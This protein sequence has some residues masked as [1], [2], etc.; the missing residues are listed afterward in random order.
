MPVWRS[1]ESNA[2][3]RRTGPA[4]GRLDEEIKPAFETAT[5]VQRL[6]RASN[7]E[8]YPHGPNCEELA[9]HPPLSHQP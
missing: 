3:Y 7:L 4:Q 6:K 8:S 2:S 1:G 5:G 9:L